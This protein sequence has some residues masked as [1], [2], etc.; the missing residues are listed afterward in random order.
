MFPLSIHTDYDK[1]NLKDTYL[2][3]P[4]MKAPDVYLILTYTSTEQM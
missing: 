1:K 3:C 2:W 4:D